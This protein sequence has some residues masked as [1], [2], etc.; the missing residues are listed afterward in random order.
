MNDISPLNVKGLLAKAT[1]QGPGIGDDTA[2]IVTGT[3]LQVDPLRGRVRVNIRGGEVWLPAVAG[4][5]S[6]TSLAR[7]LLDP[8]SERPV[9]VLGPVNPRSPSELGVVTATGA[10]EITVDVAGT[11][12]TV[13]AALGTYTVGQSAWVLLDDWGTPALALGPSTVVAPGSGGSSGGGSEGGN[14]IITA[15][16]TISPQVTG[17]YRAGKGWD[18]WNTGRYGLGN[19]PVYQGNGY[20]SGA[21]VG[22][23][24]YGN[25]IANLGALS[26]SAI[27]TTAKKGADGNSA[28]LVVQPTATGTRPAGVPASAGDTATTGS[29]ASGATGS[30]AFT[31]A[32]REA[33]RT[34]A[35]KGLAAIGSQ[36]GGFAGAGV[37]PSF[38]LKITY[39]KYA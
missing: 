24:G 13:P 15:T 4:R 26:I 25:Q 9:L 20:G 3:A 19:A 12:L 22:F 39:T 38:V 21:L 17:T 14:T 27:T 11:A 36:Y 34:G 6:S 23:I 10:G 33:F 2:L 18:Q 16:A 8:T 30:L 37:P 1:A 31:A 35:A 32:M 5:Y 28:A 29:V 7:V